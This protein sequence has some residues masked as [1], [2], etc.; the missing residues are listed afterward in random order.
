MQLSQYTR[1]ILDDI[2]NRIDPEVEDDF[3]S[4]WED[5]AYGRYTGNVFFPVRKKMNRP[6]V[7]YRKVHINDAIENYEDMLDAQL[8]MLSNR[9]ASD[10]CALGVRSNYGTGILSSLFGAP[11]FMMPRENNCLPTTRAFNDSDKVRA[12]LDAGMPDLS[13]GFGK[14]VFEFGEILRETFAPYPKISKYVHIFHPDVQGPLD[15]CE[16]MWGGEMFYEM[17]D[18]PDFVHDVMNLVSDTY[19]RFL[20]KW[21]TIVPMRKG[22]NTHWNWMHRGPLMLRDD[23]AMNL[24]PDMYEEFALP[25]DSKLL[26]HFGGG[27]VH[28]C[29]RGDHYID[30]ITAVPEAYA[31]NMSQ[32]HL[33]DMEK[34][35]AALIRSGTKIIGLHKNWAAEYDARP[36]A[37]AGFIHRN[38]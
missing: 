14:K 6:G 34:M 19:I 35:Y 30:L 27:C 1:S 24:S 4:Q 10:T 37:V 38:A 3:L 16:L 12:I 9:L 11:I 20:E 32:A 29:G 31:I 8:L 2:E 7:T 18:D 21:Y 26:K 28:F 36:D 15:I 22:M 23:S 5:F 17:Y 13:G 33:N 25:Y